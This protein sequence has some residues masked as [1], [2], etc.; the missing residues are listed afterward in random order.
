MPVVDVELP[1]GAVS[2][3]GAYA[4]GRLAAE[5][6]GGLAG[7]A[8]S[9]RLVAHLAKAVLAALPESELLQGGDYD[10]NAVREFMRVLEDRVGA[11]VVEQRGALRRPRLE[12]L[13]HGKVLVRFDDPAT[14][15]NVVSRGTDRYS[16][17]VKVIGPRGRA[18]TELIANLRVPRNV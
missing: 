2:A 17:H 8:V 16:T 4:V 1:Q 7:D 14:P 11:E 12:D 18:R 9:P 15:L 13:E 5:Y 10:Q 3:V 6:G